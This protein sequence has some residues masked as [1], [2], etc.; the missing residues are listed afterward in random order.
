MKDMGSLLSRAGF[1]LTTVDIDEIVVSYPS[2]MA[3]MEDLQNMGESNAALARNPAGL[4]RDTLV[5]ACA[6]YEAVYGQKNVDN[7]GSGG[8]GSG[9]S[10]IVAPVEFSIPATFQIIYLVIREAWKKYI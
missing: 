4:N 5:A 9:G 3:L 7:G 10:S 8:D 6:A 2:P 1:T